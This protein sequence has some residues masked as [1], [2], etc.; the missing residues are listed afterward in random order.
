MGNTESKAEE[1]K[2][3][4]D[5]TSTERPQETW[6]DFLKRFHKKHGYSKGESEMKQPKK[7]ISKKSGKRR[8]IFK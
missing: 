6:R 4:T 3:L 8:V 5:F 2:R 1:T 7:L